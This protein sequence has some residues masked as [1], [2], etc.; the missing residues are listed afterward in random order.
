MMHLN[1]EIFF[2]KRF[3]IKWFN[4]VIEKKDIN[5]DWEYLSAHPN[6]DW[7]IISNNINLPWNWK[8]VSIN[9]NITID[10][11]KSNP[12][13]KWNMVDV[14]TKLKV[15]QKNLDDIEHTHPFLWVLSSYNKNAPTKHL[16]NVLSKLLKEDINYDSNEYESFITKRYKYYYNSD[17]YYYHQRTHIFIPTVINSYFIDK[18]LWYLC[19][20]P[21][22]TF[23]LI[24]K[25]HNLNWS[26]FFL[27]QHRCI[28]W[29]IIKNNLNYNW[30]P[31][32]LYQNP[33]ITY[34]L[35]KSTNYFEL[36]DKNYKNNNKKFLFTFFKNPNINFDIFDKIL[37]EEYKNSYIDTQWY[38]TIP[39]NIGIKWNELNKRLPYHLYNILSRNPNINFDIVKKHKHKNWEFKNVIFN[40]SIMKDIVIKEKNFSDEYYYNHS[41]DIRDII[42]PIDELLDN[43]IYRMKKTY[44]ILNKYVN[45][46][47]SIM[48]ILNL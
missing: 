25:Y 44:N 48:I 5:Y 46:D 33:N 26:W 35:I 11:V 14:Y 34:D 38:D 36:I 31:I 24:K 4:K 29:D 12:H 27:S 10:I 40:S 43:Y 17:E 19:L 8:Y 32:S 22:L 37:E 6:I 18:L 23:D 39:S 2:R 3:N 15:T 1:I 41:Y 21:N 45:S 30:S 13:I 20:H 28:T 16:D 9:P 7:N 42:Q 47:I